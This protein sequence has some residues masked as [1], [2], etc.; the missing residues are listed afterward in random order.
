MYKSATT[1]SVFKG[2]EFDCVYCKPT[3]QRQA[4]RQLHNCK[5]CYNYE[6]HT[7]PERLSKIP[8]GKI[9]FVAGNADLSFCDQKYLG[10]IIDA[11]RGAKGNKTF[12]LQ[13]KEPSCLKPFVHILPANVILLTTLE[14][15]RDKGYDKVSKA[16]VP[17]KRY[18]QF[19]DLDYPRKAVTIEPVLD[20]DVKEFADWIINIKPEY[21]WL[22]YNSHPKGMTLPE[23]SPEKLAKFAKILNKH[24]IHIKAKNMRG[25]KL[26][27][28]E[29]TQEYA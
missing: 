27:N 1:W 8:S 25:I 17:S 22:G 11:I 5:K 16:P 29:N 20:F 13:S 24:S 19:L 10:K 3:F 26:P 2:C 12:Y 18:R 9:I 23:P 7:H 14:T 6:P 4:K 21:V 15:N 28:V